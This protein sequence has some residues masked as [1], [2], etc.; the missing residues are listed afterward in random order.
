MVASS[1]GYNFP[2]VTSNDHEAC[3]KTLAR[4]S[5]HGIYVHIAGIDH[6]GFKANE[7]MAQDVAPLLSFLDKKICCRPQEQSIRL[8]AIDC[9]EV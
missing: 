9:P 7:H 8:H 3:C 5:T 2:P 6:Y 1:E 4:R